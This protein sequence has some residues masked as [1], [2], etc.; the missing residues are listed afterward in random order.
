M[1]GSLLLV[2]YQSL[3]LIACRSR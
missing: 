2:Y 3:L 1:L